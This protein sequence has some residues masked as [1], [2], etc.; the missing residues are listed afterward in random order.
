M[1]LSLVE[2]L[3]NEAVE[4][5]VLG[6]SGLSFFRD[7]AWQGP[8]E[9]ID[10]SPAALLNL[11]RQI[12]E[13]SAM[14]LGLTQP[15]V[16][17]YLDYKENFFRAHVAIAPLVIKGPQIT[18]RRLPQ[19]H[20]LQL[21]DFCSDPTII[22]RLENAVIQGKSILVA[23]STGSGKTSLLT[24]LMSLLKENIR[25]LILEDSPEL[26]LPNG[27]STKLLCRINRFGF[28]SG[29]FW[30]LSHLVF[31]S[32]RMR[33]DRL[34]LGECRGPEALAIASALQTGHEGIMTTLHAGSCQQAL[35]RFQALAQKQSGDS[36]QDY[37]T[38]WNTVVF[39]EQD[40]SGHRAIKEILS[41]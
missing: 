39:I 37:K 21:Q 28:R 20:R 38:L 27:L 30:D 32:L 13:Q 36:I 22:A 15:T 40:A 19:I 14:T 34:I 17:A 1:A 6:P 8:F 33:P 23:G 26:P 10:S 31:E 12:A 41:Q 35:D 2:L 24:A 18:L 25:V 7:G 9:S 11:S 4:D 3:E 16:D 29:A 5:I